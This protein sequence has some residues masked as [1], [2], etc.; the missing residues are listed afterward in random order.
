MFGILTKNKNKHSI[1]SYQLRLKII[2]LLLFSCTVKKE[3][4]VM[5]SDTT[6][7]AHDVEQRP[8]YVH[9]TSF[10]RCVPAGNDMTDTSIIA[11]CY[12]MGRVDYCWFKLQL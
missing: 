6:Q 10:Q 11:R 1:I 4:T 3:G 9:L 12:H 8:C 2:I 7:P 5:Q